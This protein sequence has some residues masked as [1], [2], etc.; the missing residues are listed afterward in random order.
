[1][2]CRNCGAELQENQNVCSQCGANQTE[3][4]ASAPKDQIGGHDKILIILLCFFLGGFG[5]HNFVMGE[6]KK[7]VTRII[8][9]AICGIGGIIA[10]IDFIKLLVGSYVVDPEKY[11]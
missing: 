3:N 6:T 10:L 11:I 2:F 8:L 1:M 4:N 5:V 7:G 9:S